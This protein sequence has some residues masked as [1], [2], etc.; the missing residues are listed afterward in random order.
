[1][2]ITSRVARLAASCSRELE[3][4]EEEPTAAT[5]RRKRSAPGIHSLCGY[6]VSPP[7]FLTRFGL[8]ANDIRSDRSSDLFI[9]EL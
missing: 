8:A 1:M 6:G 4:D 3:A 9:V 5:T 7:G 2:E